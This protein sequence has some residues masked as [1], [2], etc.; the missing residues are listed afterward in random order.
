MQEIRPYIEKLIN[1]AS[2]SGAIIFYDPNFLLP[3]LKN[4]PKLKDFILFNIKNA[5]I[6]KSSDEDFGF[7]FN[8]NSGSETFDVIR[9]INP[10]ICFF[11]TKGA[12]GCEFFNFDN[13]IVFPA[14]KID[15]VNT[16][17]AG[18]NFNDGIIYGIVKYFE[19]LFG[20]ENYNAKKE[21]L[22]ISNSS[23]KEILNIATNFSQRVCQS[24]ENYISIKK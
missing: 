24:N 8:T 19:K 4:L 14:P 2:N 6:V 9:K 22:Q 1:D 10:N 20:N 11:Y 13:K 23:I 7:I 17:G 5:N 16:I 18:D 21:L 12:E 15:V 3:H